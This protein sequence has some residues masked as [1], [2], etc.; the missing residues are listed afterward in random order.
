MRD[1]DSA[2]ERALYGRPTA[3]SSPSS[4]PLPN[5]ADRTASPLDDAAP[6]GSRR[7]DG[8]AAIT[9]PTLHDL[10]VVVAALEEYF[11]MLQSSSEK[12]RK[13]EEAVA[14]MG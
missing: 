13:R 5:S 7:M 11:N 6:N 4:S 12:H 3:S 9:L 8:R 10:P 2:A 14:A 1:S